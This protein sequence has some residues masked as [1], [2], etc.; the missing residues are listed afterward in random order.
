MFP[1]AFEAQVAQRLAVWGAMLG[2]LL[3]LYTAVELIQAARMDEIGRD[4]DRA[5]VAMAGRAKADA[6][7]ARLSVLGSQS[8]DTGRIAADAKALQEALE[9]EAAL[10][11]DPSGRLIALETK[12]LLTQLRDRAG[13]EGHAA[14]ISMLG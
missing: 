10:T 7:F 8:V 12:S 4:I 2:F 3:V 5:A 9:Q 6:A 11:N 1:R 13:T 14:S